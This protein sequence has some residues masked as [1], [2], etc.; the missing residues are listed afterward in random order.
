MMEIN[1]HG[2]QQLAL[3][4]RSVKVFEGATNVLTMRAASESGAA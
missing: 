3:L 4:R 2:P 1:S